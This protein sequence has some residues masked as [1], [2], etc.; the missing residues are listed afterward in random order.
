MQVGRL[1]L[2]GKRE[3]FRDVH[4]NFSTAVAYRNV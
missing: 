4:Y 2:Y 1:V 3:E